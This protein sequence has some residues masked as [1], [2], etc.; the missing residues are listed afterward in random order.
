MLDDDGNKQERTV[1]TLEDYMF[2]QSE[3]KEGRNYLLRRLFQPLSGQLVRSLI[4]LDESISKCEQHCVASIDPSDIKVRSQLESLKS[5]MNSCNYGHLL[6][7]E[8]SLCEELI[9]PDVKLEDLSLILNSYVSEDMKEAVKCM[10][11]ITAGLVGI[12]CEKMTKLSP[13]RLIHKHRIITELVYDTFVWT[14]EAATLTYPYMINKMSVEYHADLLN[15]LKSAIIVDNFETSDL[16]T[17]QIDLAY[18]KKIAELKRVDIQFKESVEKPAL[19]SLE[20]LLKD[21]PVF[22]EDH[23]VDADNL[24]YSL[25]AQGGFEFNQPNIERAAESAK[26][27]VR[28]INEHI[29]QMELEPL[30]LDIDIGIDEDAMVNTIPSLSLDRMLS[31]SNQSIDQELHVVILVHGYQASSYDTAFLKAHLQFILGDNVRLVCSTAND[32]DSTKSIEVMS[33]NL[34]SEIRSILSGFRSFS[35]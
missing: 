19:S 1:K 31:V 10:F 32:S 11:E 29:P 17:R 27:E 33:R 7:S 34:I 25:S 12:N 18:R 21:C 28:E 2:A 8:K 4:F 15:R 35:R 30:N 3:T 14:L 20:L 26:S 24:N 16:K 9:H 13:Q 6:V 22:F 23:Y 5:R